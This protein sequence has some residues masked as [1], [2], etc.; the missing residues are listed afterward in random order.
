MSVMKQMMEGMMYE[1]IMNGRYLSLVALTFL[2]ASV[3]LSQEVTFSD[4]IVITT[5]ADG[6]HSV[7]SADLDGDG[8]MDV[9][10]ASQS[11][12]K[13][14]WYENTDGQGNFGPQQIL[15]TDMD[16]LSA[17]RGNDMIAIF[18]NADG[19]GNFDPWSFITDT[20]DLAQYVFS[21]DLDGDGDNDV[22]S[23]SEGD[24]K[25][26]WYENG[27]GWFERIISTHHEAASAVFSADLDGDGDMDVLACSWND[28]RIAWYENTDGAGDFGPQQIITTDADWPWSIFSADLDGDG[29]MDVLSASS[30]DDKIAWYRN[31]VITSVSPQENPGAIPKQYELCQ[32]YPNPFNPMTTLEFSLPRKEFVL[33]EVINHLGQRVEVLE[34]GNLSAGKHIYSW[35]AV[36]QP[37]GIY[38]YRL[39]T[40][41]SLETRKMLLVQ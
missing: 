12:D 15:A 6:A 26:A 22:L 20:A 34:S 11:D 3:A 35:N 30:F 32:N 8:D 29:D 38:F 25:I 16:V 31:G 9:L 33:L 39:K 18:R 17:S 36:S 13:I 1:L 10:S 23:A 28:N 21:A 4:E 24:N 37:S 14:A 2:V 27:Y 19:L 41:H 7:F 5:N 40:T